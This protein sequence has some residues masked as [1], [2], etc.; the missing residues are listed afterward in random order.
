MLISIRHNWLFPVIISSKS[1]EAVHNLWNI[2]YNTGYLKIMPTLYTIYI[3]LLWEICWV[4]TVNTVMSITNMRI[5]QYIIKYECVVIQIDL[6]KSSLIPVYWRFS[7]DDMIIWK[8]IS[9]IAFINILPDATILDYTNNEHANVLST[10]F[11][12]TAKISIVYLLKCLLNFDDCEKRNLMKHVTE[13]SH[14]YLFCKWNTHV[15]KEN[16]SE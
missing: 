5:F 1:T 9:V 7:Y 2:N 14:I 6:A 3:S 4:A 13:Y 11:S 16:I 8:Q 10:V 12:R 15:S